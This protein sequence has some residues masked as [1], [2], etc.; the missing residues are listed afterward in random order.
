MDMRLGI[1]PLHVIERRHIEK[2]LAACD[3][4]VLYAAELLEMGRSTIYRKMAEWGDDY[5]SEHRKVLAERRENADWTRANKS[6]DGPLRRRRRCEERIE[7]HGGNLTEAAASMGVTLARLQY[8]LGIWHR[9]NEALINEKARSEGISADE[10]EVMLRRRSM[11]E[12]AQRCGFSI[13]TGYK[14]IDEACALVGLRR[15]RH[16]LFLC[17]EQSS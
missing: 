11:E 8:S 1:E 9:D 14:M 12:H 10:I 16:W 2:A 13:T 4:R 17:K 6:A 7:M 3:G 5:I 15:Y